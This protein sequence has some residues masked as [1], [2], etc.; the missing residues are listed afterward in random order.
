MSS[1]LSVFFIAFFYCSWILNYI[2]K[3]FTHCQVV[4]EFIHVFFYYFVLLFF[5]TC[6]SDPLAIY[7]GTWSN[8]WIQFYLFQM[9]IQLFQHWLLKCPLFLNHLSDSFISYKISVFSG[10]RFN[11]WTLILPFQ[12]LFVLFNKLCPALC[13]FFFWWTGIVYFSWTF[14]LI[15]SYFLY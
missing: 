7:P 14:C 5:N 9:I 8:I 15:I 2:Y 4:K 13:H 11:T 6:I 1:S 10:S 12:T 3:N